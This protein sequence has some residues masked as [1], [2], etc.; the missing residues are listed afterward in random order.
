M[1]CCA[2]TLLCLRFA[3]SLVDRRFRS[4]DRSG[5]SQTNLTI[6]AAVPA[7]IAF[8][9]VV[10]HVDFVAKEPGRLTPRVGNRRFCL[11]EGQFQRMQYRPQ[12]AF[13]F[14]GF[15]AWSGEPQEDIIGIATVSEAS[16]SRI[17]GVQ[18]RQ[19]LCLASECLGRLCLSLSPQPASLL[20]E[21]EVG[22]IISS[23]FA[24]VIGGKKVRLN[25]FIEPIQV[26]VGQNRPHN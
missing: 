8:V 16:I 24:V 3:A 21:F 12:L 17:S 2:V 1:V 22:W 10:E 20:H 11:G 23:A 13:D 14:L 9:V 6:D 5:Y 7:F 4:H 15:I 19:L 26:D 25:R 18:R